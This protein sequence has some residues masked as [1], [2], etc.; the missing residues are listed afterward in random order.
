MRRGE[1]SFG[2]NGQAQYN[3]GYT[4]EIKDADKYLKGAV[5]QN[6]RRFTRLTLINTLHTPAPTVPNSVFLLKQLTLL[7]LSRNDLVCLPDIIGDLVTLRLL[8]ATFNKLT[9]IPKTIGKLVHL[10]R[11]MLNNNCLACLPS[12]LIYLVDL[13][14]IN[15]EKNPLPYFFRPNYDEVTAGHDV[16]IYAQTLKEHVQIYAQTLKERTRV[17]LLNVA[18]ETWRPR[19]RQAALT[20]LLVARRFPYARALR[21]VA[22]IIGKLVYASQGE[23]IWE[24]DE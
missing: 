19:A 21:D 15:V 24:W 17:F 20:W 12:T 16:Q 18:Q 2:D 6:D 4:L 22:Q 23:E 7:D 9:A 11:L 5:E 14:K 3:V 1:L 10:Q 13:V 8:Y